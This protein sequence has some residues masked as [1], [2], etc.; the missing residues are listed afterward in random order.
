MPAHTDPYARTYCG[1]LT[2]LG[3][4]VRAYASA[5]GVHLVAFDAVGPWTRRDVSTEHLATPHDLA[6]Y[7]AHAAGR[8]DRL[9]VRAGLAWRRHVELRAEARTIDVPWV[10]VAIGGVQ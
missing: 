7:I 4:G 5:T 1:E 3:G 2:T 10:D 8:E 9:V 6:R